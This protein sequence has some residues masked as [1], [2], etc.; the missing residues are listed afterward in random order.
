MDDDCDGICISRCLFI[1]QY[2]HPHHCRL[3]AEVTELILQF[4]TPEDAAQLQLACKRLCG[5]VCLCL[6][7][8]LFVLVLCLCLC[9]CL[10]LFVCVCVCV[11]WFVGLFGKLTS[12][13]QLIVL[14][15]LSRKSIYLINTNQRNKLNETTLFLLSYL[16]TSIT[17]N[18]ISKQLWSN[19]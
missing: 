13:T 11:C 8:C 12:T 17:S 3:P 18:Q 6:C 19:G 10:C 7:L 9:L 5:F 2:Q 14:Q 16:F 4:L 1:L 15:E